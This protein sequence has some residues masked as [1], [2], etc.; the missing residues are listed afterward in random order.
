MSRAASPGR[1][2][3]ATTLIVAILTIFGA[4]LVPPDCDGLP[5]FDDVDGDGDAVCLWT[6]TAVAAPPSGIAKPEP[7]RLLALADPGAAAAL[8]D[9]APRATRPS[10]SPPGF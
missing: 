2:A 5:G 6:R 4:M 10:R 8:F 3:W 9:D 1:R 7:P